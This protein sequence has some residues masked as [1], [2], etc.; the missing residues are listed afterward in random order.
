MASTALPVLPRNEGCTRM[1]SERK[2]IIS[3]YLELVFSNSVL[4]SARMDLRCMQCAVRNGPLRCSHCLSHSS[5]RPWVSSSEPGQLAL[6]SLA[7]PLSWI[8]QQW[9]GRAV[10]PGLKATMPRMQGTISLRGAETPAAPNAFSSGAAV[11]AVNL[12]AIRHHVAISWSL[13]QSGLLCEISKVGWRCCL[14]QD[15]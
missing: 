7:Y 15:W 4:Q 9:L 6:L 5:S 12:A 10:L 1:H 14:R 13:S 2:Q 11:S 3:Y 8:H